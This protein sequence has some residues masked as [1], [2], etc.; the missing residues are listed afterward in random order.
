M[1]LCYDHINTLRYM[2]FSFFFFFFNIK[3]G[4]IM[5][6]AN[7]IRTMSEAKLNV[8]EEPRRPRGQK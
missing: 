2:G 8:R 1:N 7:K 3:D 6:P 4:M 5:G